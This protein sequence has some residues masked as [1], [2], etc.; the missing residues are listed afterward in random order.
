MWFSGEH[1][2]GYLYKKGLYK[3]WGM[4]KNYAIYAYSESERLK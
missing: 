3:N 1:S 2:T 4:D